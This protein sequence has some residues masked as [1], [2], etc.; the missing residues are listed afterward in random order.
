MADVFISYAKLD[1]AIVETLAAHLEQSGYVVWWDTRLVGGDSFRRAIEQQLDD[2]KAVIVVWTPNSIV[3]EWVVAEAEHGARKG[4]LLPLR[5][6]E[7][8]PGAIPKPFNQRQTEIVDN[9]PAI[10]AALKRTG[11]EPRYAQGGAG[12]LHDRFWR[13]IETS[14]HPEDF[15]HYIKEF[16]EGQ[17]AAFAK[18]KIARLRRSQQ[19]TAAAP[20]PSTAPTAKEPRRSGGAGWIVA[21]LLGAGTLGG[22]AYNAQQIMDFRREAAASSGATIDRIQRVEAESERQRQADEAHWRTFNTPGLIKSWREYLALRPTGIHADEAREM[23]KARIAG[24]RLK[25]KLDGIETSIVGLT[26]SADDQ[27]LTVQGEDGQVSTW[28]IPKGSMQ[29]SVRGSKPVQTPRPTFGPKSPSLKTAIEIR[30]ARGGAASG[31]SWRG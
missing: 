22:T 16:P 19:A 3:S 14:E 6:A 1:R 12:S 20:P 11:I 5:V 13:E 23:T 26:V 18:L 7:L 28:S 8:D 10:V 25:A 9:R 2:A 4:N 24:G 15:E 17:H 21:S 31:G 29:Q 30:L 27:Q